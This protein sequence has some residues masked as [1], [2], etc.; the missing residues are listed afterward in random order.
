MRLISADGQKKTCPNIKHSVCVS[1][2]HTFSLIFGLIAHLFTM[3][4]LT[5]QM[6]GTIAHAQSTSPPVQNTT[7]PKQLQ[8]VAS[9][10][11][12]T[13]S[14]VGTSVPVIHER[15]DDPLSRNG[16]K[17]LLLTFFIGASQQALGGI[18][19][20]L[21]SLGLLWIVVHRYQ[22]ENER[23]KLLHELSKEFEK[24][25]STKCVTHLVNAGF[26]K[27]I[28]YKFTVALTHQVP[29][30]FPPTI[31]HDFSTPDRLVVFAKDGGLI[32][33][34]VLHEAL[35][36]FRRMH[37]AKQSKLLRDEHL[38][39]VWR[40]ALPFVTD[41]RYGFLKKYWGE[42]DVKVVL[43]VAESVLRHCR[44][45]KVMTPLKYLKG[46]E[47]SSTHRADADFLADLEDKLRPYLKVTLENL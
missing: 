39:Q 22:R 19:A 14:T 31:Q 4:M 5:L 20:G 1:Q 43:E 12:A 17:P 8:D 34:T 29:W 16:E 44:K 23:Q 3:G 13:P 33:S 45:N 41:G 28:K 46:P 27:G 2:S 37:R 25:A 11:L 36:W 21:V 40:Q 6:N 15:Q 42:E 26:N 9:M 18:L 47:N 30:E 35:F 7:L 32:S 38:Y 24:I 10:A